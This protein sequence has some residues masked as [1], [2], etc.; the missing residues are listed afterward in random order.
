MAGHYALGSGLGSAHFL[1]VGDATAVKTCEKILQEHT[2]VALVSAL[3]AAIACSAFLDHQGKA[4]HTV[5][6]I[7][8]PAAAG[9]LYRVLAMIWLVSAIILAGG[10]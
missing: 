1:T 8:G 6:S 5:D 9:Y 2:Q 7:W 3:Y 4:W 10:T